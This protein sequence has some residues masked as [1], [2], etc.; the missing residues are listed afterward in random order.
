MTQRCPPDTGLAAPEIPSRVLAFWTVPRVSRRFFPV[1]QRNLLVW[2][3]YLL[4]RVLSNIVEPLITLVAFG[5]GL[6][7]FLPQIDG[8]QYLPYLA[9]G[10]LCVSVMYSAKFES[11]WGAYSRMEVQHTWAAIMNAP[12]SIDDILLGEL[13]WAATKS[14]LTGAVMLLV[15]W[16]LGVAHTPWALLVLPLSFLAGMSFS[17]MALIVNA[18]AKGWDTLSTYFTVVVTPMIFLGGVF[19]PLSRLPSWL[20]EISI[21]LPL[22]ALVQL[23]R[24]LLLDRVP[25][26]VGFNLALLLFYA[27][28]CY[29]VAVGL[30][31]RRLLR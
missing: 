5:Y 6:G 4:E 22:T 9:G 8:V 7:A 16:A 29:F 28:A 20:Q 10:T 12:V 31:R 21:F 26:A 19:F 2:R 15:V 30:S 17:A 27:F 25:E 3:R 13:A 18:R 11:L 23:V 14:L 1:W 24:P